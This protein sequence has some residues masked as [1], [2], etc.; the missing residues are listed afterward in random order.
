M[1]GS[2]LASLGI[3]VFNPQKVMESLYDQAHINPVDRERINPIIPIL[4]QLITQTRAHLDQLARNT[5]YTHNISIQS[6]QKSQ[7]VTTIRYGIYIKWGD[8]EFKL[9][10]FDFIK[11]QS[12]FDIHTD[13][14]Q[15]LV[16]DRYTFN[17]ANPCGHFMACVFPEKSIHLI[18]VPRTTHVPIVRLKKSTIEMEKLQHKIVRWSNNVQIVARARKVSGVLSVPARQHWGVDS[19][20][21]FIQDSYGTNLQADLICKRVYSVWGPAIT[22]LPSLLSTMPC[23]LVADSILDHLES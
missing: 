15:L 21:V 5:I 2:R 22:R 11:G 10:Q 1:T 18:S 13:F 4:Q 17:R 3:D 20:A 9:F 14:D 23:D 12:F 19:T 6:L 7:G 8:S 16:Q